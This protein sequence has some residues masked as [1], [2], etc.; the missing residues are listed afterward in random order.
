M[1]DEYN[2]IPDGQ[3]QHGESH[4]CFFCLKDKMNCSG[5]FISDRL[6]E[7]H[8]EFVEFK[9]EKQLFVICPKCKVKGSKYIVQN[10][11]HWLKTVKLM[12]Q[13]NISPFD[14]CNAVKKAP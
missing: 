3:H 11:Q 9:K 2:T 4:R 1:A 8:P 10:L 13:H 12:K 7:L 6:V 14:V 5:F